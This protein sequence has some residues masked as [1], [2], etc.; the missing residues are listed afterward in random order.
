M[1]SGEESDDLESGGESSAP[2][3]VNA[4]PASNSD[5]GPKQLDSHSQFQLQPQSPTHSHIPLSHH[6]HSPP[7]SQQTNEQQHE[8]LNTRRGFLF[9]PMKSEPKTS[10][11]S[12]VNNNVSDQPPP[13]DPSASLVAILNSVQSLNNI[14]SNATPQAPVLTVTNQD[15]SSNPL[16]LPQANLVSDI[17]L[18]SVAEV[19]FLF[20]S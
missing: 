16:P 1:K 10:E 2:I 17:S 8:D 11:P 19:C 18:P 6:H 5:T 13:F 3:L 14:T 12:G 15:N 20:L 7:S 4:T 9:V